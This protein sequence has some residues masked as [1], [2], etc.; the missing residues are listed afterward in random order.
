VRYVIVLPDLGQTTVEAK[1]L[2]WRKRP[3]EFVSRGEPLLAVETDKVDMD[4]DSFADGYLRKILV[5]S[6]EMAVAL[7]P[8][9]ILT[10][11][12]DEP[13]EELAPVANLPEREFAPPP[14]PVTKTAASGRFA[15]TPAAKRLARELGTELGGIS[16]TGI[17]GLIVRRDVQQFTQARETVSDRALSAMA[18]VV[19]WSKREIPHFYASID[20]GLDAAEAWRTRWNAEHPEL[21]ASWNDVF[22]RC[23]SMALGDVPRLKTRLA[24]G[25]YQV[26]SANDLLLVVASETRLDLVD[27]RAPDASSWVSYLDSMRRI[28]RSPSQRR[29]ATSGETLRPLLA[30]SNLGMFGVKEFSAIIPPGCTAVLAIGA[31]RDALVAREGRPVVARVCTLTLSADH[32]VVDGV[33]AARFLGRVQHHLYSI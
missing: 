9:A 15:A 8:V 21:R 23:A 31:V 17:N 25:R 33:S 22:V 18:N 11:G 4:V 29:T 32:R 19:A 27:V 3:G 13:W 24:D 5:E 10:D 6:G 14:P 26:D 20:A 30:L 7:K 1:V 16:G 12:L 2:E 28:L